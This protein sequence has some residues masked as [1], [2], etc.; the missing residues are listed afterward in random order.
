MLIKIQRRSSQRLRYPESVLA[1][2]VLVYEHRLRV[3]LCR[4]SFFCAR[5]EFPRPSSS[6]Y[7]EERDTDNIQPPNAD[8]F[9]L[10]EDDGGR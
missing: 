1:T 7:V 6:R 4:C 5:G 9:R 2:W 10:E 8:K 3:I